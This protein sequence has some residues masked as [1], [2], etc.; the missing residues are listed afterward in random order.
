MKLTQQAAECTK[1]KKEVDV[2]SGACDQEKLE[3]NKLCRILG[4][5]L[6]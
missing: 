3:N 1:M 2:K 4:A 6:K 5:G